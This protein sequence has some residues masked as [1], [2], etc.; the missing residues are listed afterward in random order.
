MKRIEL[1]LL[2]GLGNQLYQYA[3]ARTMQKKYNCPELIIDIGEYDAFKL[4]KLELSHMVCNG[5]VTFWRVK[6]IWTS[7][8]RELFHV[9]QRVYRDIHKKHAKQHLYRIGRH[10]YMCST[11]EFVP[12]DS[13]D[14]DCLHMYGYFFSAEAALKIRNELMKEIQLQHCEHL[15]AYS[16][17]MGKCRNRPAIGVS[18]R[19][20]DDYVRNGWPICSKQYYISGIHEVMKR[21]KYRDAAIIVFADEIERI[22]EEGW[23]SRFE[24]VTYVRNLSVCESFDLLRR[25]SDY[26]C[27][28]SSFSWWGAFLTFSENP[29]IINPDK[30]FAGNYDEDDR[31]TFY[32]KLTFLDYQSGENK[33]KL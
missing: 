15:Q 4:R 26:V 3:A 12:A 32:S 19:C 1:R 11:V 16:M 8:I 22:C 7:L 23:F 6:S 13:L 24:D 18:I 10:T 17:V 27:S 25:C 21:K 2:G 9:Y 30:V 31:R 14:C 29:V 33:E 5:T 28:N 20:G